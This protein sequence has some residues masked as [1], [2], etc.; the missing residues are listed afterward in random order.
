MNRVLKV[1][2]LHLNKLTTFAGVPPM[3]VSFVL[4]ISIIIAL[5]IQRALGDANGD[6]VEGM[7][8]NSG[9]IWSL[10][11]FLIYYGV[12]A[13]ATTY[14]FALALGTTRRNFILG[15]VLANALQAAY[16]ALLLVVLLGIE[17]ATGHWFIR[18]YVFDTYL[19]GD[20]DAF[21]LAAVAF[22]GVLLCLTIG[23]FFGAVWVRF[24]PKG[25]ATVAIILGLILALALL[26]LAPR[27][28]EIFAAITGGSLAVWALAIVVLCL[29]G[30]WLAMRRASVR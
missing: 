29:V 28:G 25:P 23:G 8:Y 22:I 21:V 2:R 27:L 11:G 12:Q 1:T 26:A 9:V 14:P 3:I 6:Y 18:A 5:V 13:V 17:L 7:K 15:T 24:G 30:T 19:L 20:G 4:I 10:P 16:V